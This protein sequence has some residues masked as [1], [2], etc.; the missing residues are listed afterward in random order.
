MSSIFPI[1]LPV[2]RALQWLTSLILA[3]T[4][5]GCSVNPVTGKRELMLISEQQEFTIGAEQYEPAQQSQGG[6]YVADPELN[7]Y[8]KS[9]GRK[10]AEV[11]D[12][13]DLPY[14]FVVLNNSVPNAWALPSGKIALNRGLLVKLEDEAQLAAV[15]GHEIV[16]AAA[17][18]SAKRL[19]SNLLIS[20][21]VAGLG[22]ALDTDYKDLIVGGAALGASLAVAK[23]G[24]DHELESD[25]YGMQY[26]VK[27]GYDPQAA[28]ELQKL[29]VKLSEGRSQ[30]WVEGL[31]ASHPPSPERVLA[32]QKTAQSLPSPTFRGRQ[33]F[34]EATARLRR[35][36]PA[37]EAYESGLKLLEKKDYAGAML[38]A[39]QAIK[40]EPDEALFYSLKGDIYKARGDNR[41]AEESYNQAVRLNP[42]YF[43]NYLKRGLLN[44]DSGDTNEAVADLKKANDL[45]P[46][47]VAYLALGNIEEG[48]NNQEAA[49]GFYE[50]AAQGTG[51]IGQ[52][53]KQQY[54]KLDLPRN[55]DKYL[56][57]EQLADKRQRS[58]LAL[59]NRSALPM[60]RVTVEVTL[61]N[62]A[63]WILKKE[64][65]TFGPIKAGGKSKPQLSQLATRALGSKENR[66]TTRIEA[67]RLQ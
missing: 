13:P 46:T 55:P 6:L 34:S 15:L 3:V 18:H 7:F 4:L 61:V 40:I 67:Y 28:V 27:A 54:S 31:F 43:A 23:Y 14:E 56:V 65:V 11:S 41:K 39:D 44:K 48:R 19:Q 63:G 30:S 20:A 45:L 32:N 59:H 22:M 24:R 38:K 9:V 16:H 1:K 60:A 5:A 17:R 26:M 47:S 53:A 50:N 2:I 25:H 49:L 57:V 66:L 37:Y 12:R 8:V 58:Y 10:L 42:E 51:T 29:F 21:T 62:N 35:S 64:S 33:E 52:E 36:V